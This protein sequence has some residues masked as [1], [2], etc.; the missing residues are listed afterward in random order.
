MTDSIKQIGLDPQNG[1]IDTSPLGLFRKLIIQNQDQ[2][3][4]SDHDFAFRVATC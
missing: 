1:L 2:D 4:Y 3:Q